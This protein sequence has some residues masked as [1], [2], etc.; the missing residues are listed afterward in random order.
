MP[1]RS[2]R[3]EPDDLA[4]LEDVEEAGPSE[5]GARRLTDLSLKVIEAARGGWLGWLVLAVVVAGGIV[6]ATSLLVTKIWPL[7]DE[8]AR[9]RSELA[10][11]RQDKERLE[12]ELGATRTQKEEIERARAGLAAE[13]ERMRSETPEKPGAVEAKAAEARPDKKKAAGK[14]ARKKRTGRR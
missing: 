13:L 3:L 4:N 12:Q 10:A 2:E 7:E 11:V 14:R 6:G 9:A 5:L 8:L 1:E